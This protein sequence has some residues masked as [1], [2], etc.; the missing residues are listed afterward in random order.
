MDPSFDLFAGPLHLD[1]A[2]ALA[3]QFPLLHSCL[4]V[5][6]TLA[7]VWIVRVVWPSAA[8]PELLWTVDSPARAR[9]HIRRLVLPA[10]A[11]RLQTPLIP[12]S[13][14]C[15]S[16]I[17]TR[18]HITSSPAIRAGDGETGADGES[19]PSKS[20]SNVVQR[21]STEAARL[22]SAGLRSPAS[23]G[24]VAPAPVPNPHAF[25]FDHSAPS[26]HECTPLLVFVNPA[27]GG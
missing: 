15:R 20:S 26:A 2:A 7:A 24:F 1:S 3:P 19:T 5:V 16:P 4:L 23:R 12:A 14:S 10:D 21:V 13:N 9:A 27:S 18:R 8:H 11:I 22:V 6:A 25:V 17:A